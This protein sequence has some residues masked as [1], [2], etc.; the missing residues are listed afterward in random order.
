[1]GLADPI[2]AIRE[3]G[4]YVPCPHPEMKTTDKSWQ[5]QCLVL[6]NEYLDAREQMGGDLGEYE[7]L[8]DIAYRWLMRDERLR[9]EMVADRER[10]LGKRLG[11]VNIWDS[12]LSDLVDS[13]E[14]SLNEVAPEGYYFGMP[15]EEAG[16]KGFF[17]LWLLDAPDG[18]VEAYEEFMQAKREERKR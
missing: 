13:L 18:G 1:M 15:H 12:I 16:L 6:V 9:Q 2:K 8:R 11:T 3:S 7:A 5:G 17:P 14:F 4:Y 10:V